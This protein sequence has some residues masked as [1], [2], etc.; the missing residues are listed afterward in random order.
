MSLSLKL[1]RLQQIDTLIDQTLARLN[2]LDILLSDRSSLEQAEETSRKADEALQ[3]ERKK[4]HQAENNVRD[5]RIK[6][7]QEEAALYS[8]KMRNPKELQDLQS[9]VAALKRYLTTLEDRQLE[10]MIATEEAENAAKE[11][12]AELN[13]VQAQMTEQNAHLNAEKSNLL[14]DKERLELER[15]AACSAISPQELDLYN[16]LRKTRRGIAVARIL[17]RTCTACGSTLTPA[18]VQA[19]NSPNQIVRCSSCNRILYPG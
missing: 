10:A 3:A 6:I 8:G 7:E 2:E 9:E 1:Y 15:Q 12:K 13:K 5:Q 4:L 18:L 14:K 17:N 11:A 19:A 16:Q